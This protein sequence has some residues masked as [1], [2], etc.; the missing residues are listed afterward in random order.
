MS[1][2]GSDSNRSVV[3]RWQ[4][5]S[6]FASTAEAKAVRPLARNVDFE[7]WF[8]Q[9][10]IDWRENGEAGYLA[11]LF[12][13]ALAERRDGVLRELAIAVEEL[14]DSFPKT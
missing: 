5:S 10:L 12:S 1:S 6:T 8:D 4:M 7:S 14:G 2:I 9:A 13:T 3:P 11:D